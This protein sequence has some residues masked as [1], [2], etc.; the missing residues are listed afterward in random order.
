MN[1]KIKIINLSLILVVLGVLF[2]NVNSVLGAKIGDYGA[3]LKQ[4]VKVSGVTGSGIPQDDLASAVG[5]WIKIALGLIGTV[6]FVLIV[7]AAFNWMASQ[8]EEEKIKT[9]QKT[10]VASI[11]GLMIVVS[12]YAVSNLIIKTF[13]DKSGSG[14]GGNVKG[15]CVDWVA[16]DGLVVPIPACRITTKSD[17]EFQGSRTTATDVHA[18]PGGE[19]NWTFDPSI[20]DIGACRVKCGG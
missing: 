4:V 2:F 12:A 6:F 20:L 9:S 10:I 7:Y 14:G 16:S 8:G 13:V 17:C 5:F 19:G 3:P 15:C 18:G 11:I 1:K